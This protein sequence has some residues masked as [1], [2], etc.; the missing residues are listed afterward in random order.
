MKKFAFNKKKYIS[1]QK[2]QNKMYYCTKNNAIPAIDKKYNLSFVLHS[3][4][5]STLKIRILFHDGVQHNKNA[6]QEKS[7]TKNN[8][9]LRRMGFLFFCHLLQPLLPPYFLYECCKETP[10]I[11]AKL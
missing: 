11:L 2:I 7:I 6:I 8:K 3:K 1:N 9:V 4:I 10:P 5:I